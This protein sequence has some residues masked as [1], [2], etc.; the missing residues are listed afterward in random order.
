[1][2]LPFFIGAGALVARFAPQIVR[3]VTPVVRAAGSFISKAASKFSAAPLKTQATITAG[4]FIGGGII[5]E[6]PRVRQTLAKAPTEVPKSL[7]NIGGNIGK[8]I[9][10]PSVSSAK[11]IVSQNPVAS[12]ILGA[13]L[14]VT[15]AGVVVKAAPAII[16]FTQRERFIGAIQDIPRTAPAVAPIPSAVVAKPPSFIPAP[17]PATPDLKPS[18]IGLAGAPPDAEVIGASEATGGLPVKQK[19][20]AVKKRKRR[21]I[22]SGR[23]SQSVKIINVAASAS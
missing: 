13:A 15:A 23:Q 8:F 21:S 22:S 3:A 1:M 5:K 14:V 2:V 20:K 17:I 11:A 9:E 19:S 10:S 6:S 18:E 7:V 4:T 16:G 12:S